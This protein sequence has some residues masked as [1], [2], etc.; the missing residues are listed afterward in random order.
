MVA[1]SF[2]G[3]NNNRSFFL[4]PKRGS[5]FEDRTILPLVQEFLCT[6]IRSRRGA[7]TMPAYE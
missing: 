5:K 4:S 6:G 2:L 1:L 3:H 7:M